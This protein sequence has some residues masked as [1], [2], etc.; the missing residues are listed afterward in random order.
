[1]RARTNPNPNTNTNPTPPPFF[2]THNGVWPDKIKG[3]A[4]SV[5]SGCKGLA[6]ELEAR[7]ATLRDGTGELMVS[8]EGMR[9]LERCLNAEIVR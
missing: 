6:G 1:M 3:N 4:A 8:L 2:L 9:Q 7:L 5:C